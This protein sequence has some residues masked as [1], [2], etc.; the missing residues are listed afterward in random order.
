MLCFHGPVWHG[1]DRTIPPP[2]LTQ[3]VL[4]GLPGSIQDSPDT[5]IM[6]TTS[7]PVERMVA[8]P[9][10]TPQKIS[11]TLLGATRCAAPRHP[12]PV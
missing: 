3:S 5:C 6:H 11:K 10:D 9:Q 8:C 4:S 12:G 7:V 1:A 2:N